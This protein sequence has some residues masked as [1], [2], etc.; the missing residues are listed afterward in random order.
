MISNT[1]TSTMASFTTSVAGGAA[2]AGINGGSSG[3]A[4]STGAVHVIRI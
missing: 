3:V 1:N 4:G 2:A